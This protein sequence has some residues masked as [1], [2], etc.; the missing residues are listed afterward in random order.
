[1]SNISVDLDNVKAFMETK[2]LSEYRL[3][4]LMNVSY[5]YVYRVMRGQ[6]PPGKSF[7]NGLINAG[8]SPNDIFLI[9]SL[10]KGNKNFDQP[11]CREPGEGGET[12]G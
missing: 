4:K 7:V 10:P 9:N 12:G 1:M 6:R 11:H 2:N 5:S 3:A 8:I